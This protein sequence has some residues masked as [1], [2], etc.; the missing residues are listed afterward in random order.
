MASK[1]LSLRRLRQGAGRGAGPPGVNRGHPTHGARAHRKLQ[2]PRSPVKTAFGT[3]DQLL[4]C[5]KWWLSVHC[6]LSA[7][8]KQHTKTDSLC[9]I[10]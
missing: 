7:P 2:G 1:G 6:P 8:D 4:A 3:K 10:Q 9:F 5:R